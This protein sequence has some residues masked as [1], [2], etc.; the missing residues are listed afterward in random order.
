MFNQ[1][2]ISDDVLFEKVN[3]GQR[4]ETFLKKDPMGRLLVDRAL[5][6]YQNAVYE[7]EAMDISVILDSPSKVVAIRHK[8]DTA[9]AFILWMNTTITGADRAEKELENRDM[10]DENID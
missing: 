8:M 1:P 7:F 10:S 4:A 9:K 3:L 2:V 6:E 5:L